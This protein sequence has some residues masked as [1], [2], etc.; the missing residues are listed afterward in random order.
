[1]RALFI[2]LAQAFDTVPRTLI[3]QAMQHYET[4][5]HTRG[6]FWALYDGHSFAVKR[7]GEHSSK[8]ETKTGTKQ[9]CL[10]SP[11]IFNLCLQYV[12]DRVDLGEGLHFTRGRLL[13]A[14]ESLHTMQLGHLLYADDLAAFSQSLDELKA[15]TK[16]LCEK[17]AGFGLQVNFKKAK[18]MS[19][20]T[21]HDQSVAVLEVE[22]SK[23]ERVPEFSYLG[24]LIS[25]DGLDE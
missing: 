18:L 19:F 16:T 17:P 14:S 13:D 22:G 8:T 1:M 11:L 4:P 3:A 12:L 10:L 21:P 23:I 6:R 25:E 9:D 5:Q 24:S 20:N 7:E 2:D 15:T